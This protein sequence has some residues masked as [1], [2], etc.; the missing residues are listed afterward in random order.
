MAD[1]IEEDRMEWYNGTQ[2]AFSSRADAFGAVMPF[3][4]SQA[5]QAQGASQSIP[6][7]ALCWAESDVRIVRTRSRESCASDAQEQESNGMQ[8]SSSTATDGAADR[9]WRLQESLQGTE[10]K[11][12][13]GP[14][15]AAEVIALL[16]DASTSENGR[17][18]LT[19]GHVGY[20]KY[21]HYKGPCPVPTN[22]RRRLSSEVNGDEKETEAWQCR[23]CH[24]QIHVPVDQVSN[25]GGHLYGRGGREACLDVRR[26]A[27]AEEIPTP[28]RD[29]SGTLIKL[30]AGKVKAL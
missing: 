26:Q 27:Y 8:A 6:A 18:S 5:T 19:A 13:R 28:E 15:S 25:L 29:A 7:P 14:L 20:L 11:A 10:A 4:A 22:R 12:Y 2:S 16:A 30:R 1:L 9:G 21:F 23:A 17:R 24:K 3:A